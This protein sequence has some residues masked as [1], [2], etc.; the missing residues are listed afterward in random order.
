MSTSRKRGGQIG[1]FGVGVKS[2]LVV[3][4][5]PEFFSRT[6]SFGFDRAWSYELIRNVPGVRERL[7]DQFEAPVLRM[8]RE[9]DMAAERLRDQVLDELLEWATTVVR[10][11]LLPGAADRLGKDMHGHQGAAAMTPVRSSL[12]AS[13]CSPRTWATWSWKIVGPA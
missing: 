4:D 10:L 1:R 12:P 11:P 2:V 3:T 7:G 8:A 5:A 6:G 13:T 9:L